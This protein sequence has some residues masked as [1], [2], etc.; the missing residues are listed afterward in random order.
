MHIPRFVAPSS[1]SNAIPVQEVSVVSPSQVAP[2]S[3][4]KEGFGKYVPETPKM[5]LVTNPRARLT[6]SY[7]GC[8]SPSVPGTSRGCRGILHNVGCVIVV[9]PVMVRLSRASGPR[10]AVAEA[11]AR[12]TTTVDCTLV[13]TLPD[14]R[15]DRD[16]PVE[17]PSTLTDKWRREG[18]LE[19]ERE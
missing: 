9:P 10:C 1:E 2:I 5:R 13:A 4:P 14:V 12:A 16:A 11:G 18:R 17:L 7:R 3:R 15:T 6:V 19:Q 8:G